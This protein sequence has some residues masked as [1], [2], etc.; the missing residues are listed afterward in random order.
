MVTFTHAVAWSPVKVADWFAT[1]GISLSDDLSAVL[2][3]PEIVGIV[4]APPHWQY[5]DQ[6]VQLAKVTSDVVSLETVRKWLAGEA[7]T[8]RE[9]V[10]ALD[11]AFGGAPAWLEHGYERGPHLVRL[12]LHDQRRD[13][14]FG[15]S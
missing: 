13:V 1:Q 6:I 12:G 10:I 14:R 8:R 15:C 5:R 7:H 2:A 3:D 9:R 4:L 11:E